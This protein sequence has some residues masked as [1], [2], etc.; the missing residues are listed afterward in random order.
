MTTERGSRTLVKA[1][2]TD[3]ALGTAI[4]AYVR[5]YVQRYGR[6]QAAHAF[7]V[8]RYTLWRCLARGHLGR[9]LPR[10]ILD[11]VG[12][13]VAALEAATWAL[14]APVPAQRPA[15]ARCPLPA[16]LED[17]LLLLCATPLAT[18]RELSCCGRIPASTLRDRLA[19]LAQRG[20]VGSVPH[21]LGL[22]GP[23]P[24]RRY[25]PTPAGLTA[26]SAATADPAAFL[27]A[28]PVSR[29]WF[30]LLA[31]RLDAV[32]V[33]YHVAALVAAAD[34][35]G[36]PVRVD[37][38][39]QGPYDALVTLSGGR[40]MG[41][42]RQGPLLP[43]A[44][45]R[46]RLHSLERLRDDERPTV[47]LLLTYADQ[48]TR[49]AIRAI[50][51][52]LHHRTTFV[53]TA[54]ELLAGGAAAVVWQQGGTGIADHPPAP[55]AP[56]AAL[57]DI[58]AWT[59]CRLAGAPVSHRPTPTP[60]PDALYAADVRATTPDPFRQLA[61]A[62]AVQLT[63]A[64][65]ETLDLLAAW[66]R[67]TRKQL[68]GL[69]GG[70]T[71]HRAGQ[72]LRSLLRRGLVRA[73]GPR[74]VLTD[75]ALKYLAHR[76]RAAVGPTLA[77][78][79]AKISTRS[80][81]SGTGS[82]PAYAGTALRVLATQLQHHTGLTDFAAALTAEA[83]R[84]PD[85]E[86]FDL[87]PTA[88]SAVGYWHLGTPYVVHPDASFLLAYRG[89]WRPYLLEFER[90]ATTPRRVPA[91]LESYRRYFHSGW[92]ARDHDGQ[93]PHVLFVFDS[94]ADEASFRRVAATVERAPFLSSNLAVLT[95]RGVLGH[96]WRRPP[97]HHPDRG[98]LWALDNGTS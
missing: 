40:S 46:Y 66:P 42:L 56:D 90:R 3:C 4:R 22:L 48:A 95:A 71:R 83:S 23:H 27:H 18:V 25:F 84:A 21:R 35:S 97:P 79:S 80:P 17:T 32:A 11:T 37:H 15:P 41:L 44:T 20:L 78:W 85:Y 87:L 31:A 62:L 52:P 73:E 67:C 72:A 86:L 16:G 88:R 64:D 91:R 38:C 59:E 30:R 81:H 2:V 76:D 6:R 34:P 77:Q 9:A 50:G 5:A 89:E 93:L 98:Q 28:Y 49:R 19:T 63:R 70:V 54:G 10:A 1:A 36:Q 75:D 65:K 53:A 96:A 14:M 58:V 7:G 82:P 24:Q 68:A 45:L 12:G 43:T 8:S 57:A 61:T 55:I 92:A 29:Q 39:R 13:S 26:A 60:D 94:P 69:M 47:T 33:L 74:Y 51:D